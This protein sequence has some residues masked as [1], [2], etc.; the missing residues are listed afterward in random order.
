MVMSSVFSTVH[1]Q[2]LFGC[3]FPHFDIETANLRDGTVDD[4][5]NAAISRVLQHTL[6]GLDFLISDLLS[7]TIGNSSLLNEPDHLP[8]FLKL[9]DVNVDNLFTVAIGNF[10]A[11]WA[12]SAMTHFGQAYFGQ[13]YFG[14]DLVWPRPLFGHDLVW[15]RP[16]LATTLFGHDLV[17]P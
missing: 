5:V 3:G 13:T 11:G 10:L 6:S 4:L 9:W 7:H 8:G 15:P 12:G 2:T 17:W 1:L 14:H 16:C